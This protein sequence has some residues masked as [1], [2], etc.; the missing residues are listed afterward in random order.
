MSSD[1]HLVVSQ[2]H[3]DAVREIAKVE[4][5]SIGTMAEMLLEESPKFKKEYDKN[6]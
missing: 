4:K 2:K 6:G 5:R 3:G 1:Q